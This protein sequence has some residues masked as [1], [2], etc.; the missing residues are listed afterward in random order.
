M[1]SKFYKSATA[2]FTALIL[3]AN[4]FAQ[5][6]EIKVEVLDPDGDPAMDAICTL[7]SADQV[8]GKQKPDVNATVF[9]KQVVPGFYELKVEKMGCVT[10]IRQKIEV[11]A[12]KTKY[13]NIQLKAKTDTLDD[14]VIVPDVESMVQKTMTIGMNIDYTQIKN[15]AAP[16]ND[17]INIIVNF[18]P[19]VLPTDDG[20]DLYVRGARKG[21]NQYF[22]DGEKTF[23]T[24]D[25]PGQAVQGVVVYT[26][27]VP[28]MY[29][30]FTGG[31]VMITTKNYFSGMQQ[32]RNMIQQM[33]ENM[34]QEQNGNN[35]Q[36][37]IIDGQ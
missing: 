20:K 19:G 16:R 35:N 32:K 22:V 17:V 28:A 33:E 8:I 25:V 3:S 23:G 26:G 2:V 24:F 21:S 14:I 4:A 31:V 29:G 30:D 18:T 10:H 5:N 15:G 7:T 1:K 12:N 34:Q 37:I 27:G 6:G 36:D 9:Y 13:I 11:A